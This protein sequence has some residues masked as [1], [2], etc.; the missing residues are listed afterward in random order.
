[1]KVELHAEN[2][3][4]RWNY[5]QQEDAPSKRGGVKRLFCKKNSSQEFQWAYAQRL[6]LQ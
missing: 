1:M 5:M 4:L 2:K 6:Q 3:T